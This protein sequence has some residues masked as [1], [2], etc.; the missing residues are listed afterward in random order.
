MKVND[1]NFFYFPVIKGK[2]IYINIESLFYPNIEMDKK[3]VKESL[4]VFKNYKVL[5]IDLRNNYGG[6]SLT[7]LTC[8]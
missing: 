3:K 1:D 4:N 7:L 8:F 6:L 5:I 2:I